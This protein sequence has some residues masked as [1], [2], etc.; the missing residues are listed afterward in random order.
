MQAD[1]LLEWIGTHFR[2][3]KKAKLQADYLA[4]ELFV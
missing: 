1:G 4:A 2:L 3:T